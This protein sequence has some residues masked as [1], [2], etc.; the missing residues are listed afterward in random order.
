MISQCYCDELRQLTTYL[1]LTCRHADTSDTDS[2]DTNSSSLDLW[3]S[4]DRSCIRMKR[5]PS[6]PVG[7]ISIND[8]HMANKH[9]DLV[10]KLCYIDSFWHTV[11]KRITSMDR[12]S[13]IKNQLFHNKMTKNADRQIIHIPATKYKCTKTNNAEFPVLMPTMTWGLRL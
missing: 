4:S 9:Y 12:M 10:K 13:R 5:V 3:R 11:C 1:L 2:N 7:K 6:N 8:L